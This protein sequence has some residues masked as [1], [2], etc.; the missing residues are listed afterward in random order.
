M[1][2]SMKP[3]LAA[4]AAGSSLLAAMFG[5]CAV[6]VAGIKMGMQDPAEAAR[7]RTACF[8]PPKV[9]MPVLEHAVKRAFI[10]TFVPGVSAGESL[11]QAIPPAPLTHRAP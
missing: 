1:Q 7:V 2:N 4:C 8:D 10:C 5:F 6:S 9:N 3:A 11:R